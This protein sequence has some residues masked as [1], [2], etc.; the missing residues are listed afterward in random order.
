MIHGER[1]YLWRAVDQEGCVLDILEQRRR[2]KKAAK[3]F[4]RKLLKGLAYAPRVINTDKLTSYGAA[5]REVLPGVKHRQHRSD[6]VNLTRLG[7]CCPPRV[8]CL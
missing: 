1:H 6:S 7:R 2:N 3:E 4:F 8:L 5:K